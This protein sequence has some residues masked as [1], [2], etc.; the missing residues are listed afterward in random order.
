MNRPDLLSFTMSAVSGAVS[1]AAEDLI[2][3]VSDDEQHHPLQQQPI[4]SAAIP[5]DVTAANASASAP[6]RAAVDQDIFFPPASVPPMTAMLPA[7]TM[8]FG[9]AG[10]SSAASAS[11]L[12]MA[13]ASLQKCL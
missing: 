13:N 9:A 12:A 1:S 2:D 4:V 10:N 3:L 5:V 6:K 8:C 7:M 11:T